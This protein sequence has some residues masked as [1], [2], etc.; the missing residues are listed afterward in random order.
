MKFLYFFLLTISFAFC[1]NAQNKL[2]PNAFEQKIQGDGV[3]LIDVRTPAEYKA[4]FIKNARN[5]NFNSESFSTE[6]AT[7]DK[8]RTVYVYCA[9]GG[10]SSKASALLLSMGFKKVI[11]LQG[12]FNAWQA[13]KK[14]VEK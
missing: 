12:G 5:I 1:T 10:R 14:P 7:L 13:E 11:D 8:Q 3:Q 4:G 9:V 6:V 2:S